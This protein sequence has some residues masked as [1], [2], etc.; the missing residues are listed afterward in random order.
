MRFYSVICVLLLIGPSHTRACKVNNRHAHNRRIVLHE[1]FK[2]SVDSIALS[3]TFLMPMDVSELTQKGN[4]SIPILL[5]NSASSVDTLI[6]SRISLLQLKTDSMP[7]HSSTKQLSE[8]T[9]G[10]K[11]SL[12]SLGQDK[13]HASKEKIV[14]EGEKISEVEDVKVK[15]PVFHFPIPEG[16][17]ADIIKLK[18]PASA[19][20]LSEA[21]PPSS[22][23]EIQQT[24]FDIP[25]KTLP[26]VSIK[27]NYLHQQ[28]PNV[29]DNFKTAED[30]KKKIPETRIDSIADKNEAA[31]QAEKQ[32][33]DLS[34]VKTMK[35]GVG[36]VTSKQAEYEEMMQRYSDKKLV[37]AEIR[38]KMKNVASD[39]VNQF[40]PA[41]NEA[42]NKLLKGRRIQLDSASTKA[43]RK[44][45][46][47]AMASEPLANRLQ[48]GLVLQLYNRTLYS[49]DFGLQLGY[50]LSSKI[51][52]GIGGVYRLGYHKD[53]S[54]YVRSMHVYGGR[55]YGDVTVKSGFFAHV[56][57]ELLRSKNMIFTSTE[58]IDD[59]VLS[60][61][62]GIGKQYTLSKRLKGNILLL[63]RAELEGH[64]PEQSKV[65]IRIGLMLWAK[66]KPSIEP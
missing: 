15:M 41:I 19:I 1:N 34:E 8:A 46:R 60:S 6:K 63:Y 50:R 58:G 56:E 14:R 55:L 33:Q 40:T 48:S 20:D 16:K 47:S 37:E 31:L 28:P 43:I 39:K 9:Y 7:E 52:T 44:T 64:L 17:S 30:Y 13:L 3:D 12:I 18:M 42:Q 45:L 2:N 22:I 27:V 61:S 21:K 35:E 57:T 65:N 5:N 49:V 59:Y 23:P 11:D 4:D 26:N 25:K 62:F 24:S 66:R 36:K 29:S 10:S 51:T 54:S 53:Y 38:R 32:V